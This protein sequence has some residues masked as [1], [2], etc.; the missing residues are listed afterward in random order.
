MRRRFA[1]LGAADVE[2]GIAAEFNLAPFQIRNLAG[3]ETV[4][5]S[6]EDERRV[7]MTIAAAA[8]VLPWHFGSMYRS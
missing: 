2:R 6:D 7:T 8:G 5:I 4:A 1:V 3:A